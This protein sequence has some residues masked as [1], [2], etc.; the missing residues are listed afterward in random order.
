MGNRL[1]YHSNNQAQVI[2]HLINAALI[3]K[4]PDI[5]DANGVYIFRDMVAVTKDDHAGFTVYFPATWRNRAA[6]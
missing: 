1:F 5:S 6:T 4:G 2:M 3:G